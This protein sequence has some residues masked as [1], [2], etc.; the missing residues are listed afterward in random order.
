MSRENKYY[1][2]EKTAVVLDTGAMIAKYYNLLPKSKID[3]YTTESA[4]NEVLDYES[5]KSLVDIVDLGYL[6]VTTP[7]Q[8]SIE[9]VLEKALEIGSIHKLSHTD[10]EI[11]A[12]ALELSYNYPRVVVITDDYELQNLL[13]YMGIG[14][15][16]LRT[17]GISEL[18]V[19]SA[20]CP[21][22]RYVPGKPGEEKCPLC[23]SMI[24]RRKKRAP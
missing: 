18:R 7:G 21:V 4:V 19:F 14:F 6:K 12:L 17:R 22:C 9:V 24:T 15:R 16:A 3:M 23:G 8:R 2:V 13:L 5:R 1:D 11:A 10:I 20:Y